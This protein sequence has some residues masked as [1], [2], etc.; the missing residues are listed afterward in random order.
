M[1]R[2]MKHGTR[3]GYNRH[4]HLGQRA[5]DACND[6]NNAY[7]REYYRAK[8]ERERGP[9]GAR[10]QGCIASSVPSLQRSTLL[11]C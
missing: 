10:A 3:G 11:D 7:M 9:K 6:A 4:R 5:C 8:T 2:T 1:A